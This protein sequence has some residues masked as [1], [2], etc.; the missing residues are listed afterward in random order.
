MT[1]SSQSS[2]ININF[3]H[4][5]VFDRTPQLIYDYDIVSKLEEVD[6]N[7][8]NFPQFQSFLQLNYVAFVKKFII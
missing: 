4:G 3:H 7:C 8:M 6:I 1:S 2:F 5:R